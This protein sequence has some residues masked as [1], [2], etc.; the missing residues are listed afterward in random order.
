ME[1][2]DSKGLRLGIIWM[3]DLGK[4][5][6]IMIDPLVRIK[7]DVIE[8]RPLPCESIHRHVGLRCVAKVPT[9]TPSKNLPKQLK[10]VS[11]GLSKVYILH[12]VH[13]S[14]SLLALH[15]APRPGGFS[16]KSTIV[17]QKFI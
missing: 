1:N 11:R 16:K 3:Q 2:Y 9:A 5:D 14:R 8:L 6:Q 7:S 15:C 12:L 17:R 13:H 4:I 10:I